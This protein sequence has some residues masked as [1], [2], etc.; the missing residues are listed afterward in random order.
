MNKTFKK[1]EALINLSSNQK[2]KQCI[3]DIIDVFEKT[4][5]SNVNI[6]SRKASFE[7]RSK[8]LKET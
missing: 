4:L 8:I 5:K 3:N 6:K 7:K 2:K 1:L